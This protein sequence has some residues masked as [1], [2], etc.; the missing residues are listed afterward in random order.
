MS[1]P[2]ADKG[3]R[4]EEVQDLQQTQQKGSTKKWV[5]GNFGKDKV[6]QTNSNQKEGEGSGKKIQHENIS[7]TK[8]QQQQQQGGQRH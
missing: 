1:P 6:D 2:T 4:V 8:S 5:K 7:P 3:Q